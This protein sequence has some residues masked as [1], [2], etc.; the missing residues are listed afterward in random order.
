MTLT[1][2]RSLIPVR[3]PAGIFPA[4]LLLG[5]GFS[6]Q[7]WGQTAVL[8]QWPL[9]A[10]GTP[11]TLP[12]LS[13]GT[14]TLKR[15][16]ASNG[17]TA[18]GISAYSATYGQATAPTAD[19]AWTTGAGGPGGTLQRKFY[20]QFTV[21]ADAGPTTVRL[22]SLV[23]TT[24]FYATVS[25]TRLAV[26]YST[27]GFATDSTEIS[28]GTLNGAAVTFAANGGFNKAIGVA[29]NNAG[30]TSPTNTYRLA[31]NGT[32]GVTLA[33]GQTLSLRLYNSCG[34]SS[35]GKYALLKNV[36][37]KGQVLTVGNVTTTSAD[38][39]YSA[40]PGYSY[41]LS[42][43]DGVTTTP[44]PA[45]TASP[46]TLS[47]LA[48]G[49]AYTATL[50]GTLAGFPGT[51]LTSAS[52]TT[53]GTTPTLSSA[54]LQRWLLTA[55]NNDDAATRSPNVLASG[56]ALANMAAA[57][58]S[59]AGVTA[60]TT[61]Y[62]QA[63]APTADGLNW[64]GTIRPT[65]YEE[66]TT[67]AT[68]GQL[69][70]D[71]LILSS[72]FYN[73]TN[74]KLAVAYS[75]DGFATSTY[76]LGSA[77]APVAVN[78]QNAGFSLFRLPL[79]TGAGVILADGQRI[80]FRLYFALGTS[81]SRYAL[82][83]T[84]AVK[85][86]ASPTCTSPTGFAVGTITSTSARVSFT[87]GTGNTGYVV[88]YT[89]A[90]GSPV[91][92]TPA[93]TASPVSLTGLAPGTAYTVTLQSTCAA[94]QGAVLS[95][96]FTTRVVSVRLQQWPLQAD[97]Q[98]DAA[99][100][101][102]AVAASTASLRRMQPADGSVPSVPAYSGSN[103]QGLAPTSAGTWN[104]TSNPATLDNVQTVNRKYYEQFTLT[105]ASGYNVRLDS[106]VLSA[107]SYN[108]ANGRMAVV[109]SRS[110]FVSDSTDV[111]AGGRA[112]P[113]GALPA[114]SYGAFASVI[115]LPNQTSGLSTT[116]RLPLAPTSAGLALAPGQ[117]LTVR[118][119]FGIG[120]GSAGR[121]ALLRDVQVMGQGMAL[122]LPVTLT[123]F[124][125]V[126][127]RNEALLTWATASEHNSKGFA[128]QVSADGHEFRTVGFVPSPSANSS[129]AQ[130]Y[131]FTDGS[132][133][134]A[135]TYYYR[136]QQLDLDGSSTY[137]PTR[138]LA[139]GTQETLAQVSPNPFADKLY[140]TT[141]ADAPARP[142]FTLTDARGRTVLTQA[143]DLPA[144]RATIALPSLAHLPK[145]MYVLH[146]VLNQQPQHIKLLKE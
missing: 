125:A 20:Q 103:G 27:S 104:T 42:Y 34:S 71:S 95:T 89:A 66:F 105:A 76:L 39:T 78:N 80:A 14:P 90:G 107:A 77:A 135:G 41:A 144:G 28:G 136:L 138:A 32:A 59:T 36:A 122:P 84:V 37:L 123:R 54:V 8:S 31:L 2:L 26:V 1:L 85:G 112:T 46:Y 19:G 72:A 83:K 5:A 13:A 100:R 86:E 145:G 132:Q 67:T 62:G 63:T 40:A 44:A 64:N 133:S 94:G 116:Y 131:R 140:L 57:D 118:V 141:Q 126:R 21:T 55:D 102:A 11:T 108:S 101:S 68:N 99:V 127:Q 119:Y 114:A 65:Y 12:G 48:P 97:M 134:A 91:T 4:A 137:T 93:P 33:A 124:E 35:T 10:T 61:T 15:M 146:F 96:T 113:G 115:A 29:Q 130:S 3:W 106:L 117:T 6:Q 9:T 79:T 110:S 7:A 22:D 98:D 53:P 143:L 81:S 16:T 74:G 51:T 87:P 49:K 52:F 24:A 50:T 69:R 58:G 23:L 47:G 25:N 56:P 82:L 45:P 60:N 88:T 111:A 142:V 128:V 121:Y 129:Q 120:S 30:P 17:T 18:P 73:T 139:L 75:T 92:V 43:S 109:Y 70:L 38:L